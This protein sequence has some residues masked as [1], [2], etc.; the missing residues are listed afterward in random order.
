MPRPLRE[1]SEEQLSQL[2]RVI[3][4]YF[5]QLDSQTPLQAEFFRAVSTNS[6]KFGGF[7]VSGIS[8][9]ITA[10]GTTQATATQVTTPISNVT[11]VA[12]GADGVRL[13]IAQP[14]VQV[15]VRNS[16][17]VDSLNIYPSTGVQINAL[18]ANVAFSLVAGSTIQLFSTT[19]AQWFTF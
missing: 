5:S 19:D 18:G 10:A 16:D 17:A 2:I 14:G 13:P 8:P 9:D 3:E 1:Y 15:L 11:V 7:F 6:E 12:S 4:L